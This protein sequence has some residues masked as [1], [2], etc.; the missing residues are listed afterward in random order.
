[1]PRLPRCDI[2]RPACPD[3]RVSPAHRRLV[4]KGRAL[5]NSAL[6]P[7]RA[8]KRSAR[9]ARATL[10]AEQEEIRDGRTPFHGTLRRMRVRPS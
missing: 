1:M 7:G 4:R 10:S 5:R 3:A 2:D 9:S 6:A 8:H